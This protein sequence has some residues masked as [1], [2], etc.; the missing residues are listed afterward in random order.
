MDSTQQQELDSIIE[1]V[2]TATKKM[3]AADFESFVYELAFSLD[4]QQDNDIQTAQKLLNSIGFDKE[5]K[6]GPVAK[7]AVFELLILFADKASGDVNFEKENF[8]D[9]KNVV[10]I[11]T[12]A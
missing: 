5:I 9:I 8:D 10:N 4:R 11:L 2:R 7:A 6:K 12:A 1:I 3:N